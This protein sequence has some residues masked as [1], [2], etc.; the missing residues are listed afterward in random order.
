ML[1]KG[2]NFEFAHKLR[3]DGSRNACRCIK[4][5]HIQITP[6]YTAEEDYA[7]YQ[8]GKMYERVFKDPE[9][10]KNKEKLANRMRAYAE[11]PSRKLIPYLRA[12]WRILEI[13]SSYGW[14]VEYLQRRGYDID[15]VEISEDCRGIYH[16]RTGK[17]LLSFNFMT[18]EPE[19]LAKS[20]HYDCICC[21]STLEH[22]NDPV[23]FISRAAKLL[24][25]GG[26]I[27]IDVPNENDYM[28]PI[29]AEYA[30]HHYC[31]AHVSYF[32]P[33]TLTR[34]LE[35]CG[36]GKVKIIGNQ[37]YSPENASQWLRYKAPFHDYHQ[38]DLPEPVQWLNKIYKDRMESEMTSTAIIGIG[39]KK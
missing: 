21:F 10:I 14:L 38:I 7:Y 5:G 19:V 6:L 13:G 23:T 37:I 24:R 39:Y 36:F 8:S 33:E 32:F 28:L 18:D 35:A 4:C 3:N 9:D 22:I 2:A 15:G 31:R 26:M 30:E 17:E 27:Y 1:C 29:S 20:E 12:D 11:Y 34:L 25:P 16:N